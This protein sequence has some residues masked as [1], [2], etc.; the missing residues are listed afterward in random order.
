MWER[1]RKGTAVETCRNRQK[2]YGNDKSIALEVRSFNKRAII[3]YENFG[4]V[5]EKIYFKNTLIG[6]DE[7]F[8]MELIK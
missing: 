2:K 7:F 5:I 3:C 4:F 8:Y 6:E 1:K